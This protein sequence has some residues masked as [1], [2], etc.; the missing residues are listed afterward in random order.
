MVLNVAEIESVCSVHVSGASKVNNCCLNL[1]KNLKF[2]S[3]GL[4]NCLLK[5]LE[6][7]FKFI[8]ECWEGEDGFG[9]RFVCKV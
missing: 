1:L 3:E 6:C 4:F 8:V 2:C 5:S 7:E 9:F